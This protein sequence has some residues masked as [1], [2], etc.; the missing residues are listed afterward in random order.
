MDGICFA[1]VKCIDM[2]VGPS[3]KK[4]PLRCRGLG[5]DFHI[6]L[7]VIGRICVAGRG[8]TVT[9]LQQ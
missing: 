9:K 4:V 2:K 8:E 5:G 3:A 7:M 6:I 1:L